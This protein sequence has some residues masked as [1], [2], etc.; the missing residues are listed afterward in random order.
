MPRLPKAAKRLGP[1]GWALAVGELALLT[2]RH[3]RGVHPS[4]RS[5]LRELVTKSRGRPSG[6]TAAERREVVRLVRELRLGTLGRDL[7][8]AASPLRVPGAGRRR[9]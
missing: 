4:T 8:R 3:W 9:R 6:L 5:R 1:V 2:G 7:A